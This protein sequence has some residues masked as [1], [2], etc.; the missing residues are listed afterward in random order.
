MEMLKIPPDLRR[1]LQDQNALA[2]TAKGQEVFQG[3][4]YEE[5]QFVVA[6]SGEKA[7]SMSQAQRDRYAGLVL[8]HEQARMR[9]ASAD[10]EVFK[11][12]ER[13]G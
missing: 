12:E 8:K 2:I 3:L 9:R 11:D 1:R 7:D 5:S 10:D 4:T 13:L 6:A